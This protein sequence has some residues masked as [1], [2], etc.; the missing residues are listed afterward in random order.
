MSLFCFSQQITAWLLLGLYCASQ[1][2]VLLL[3]KFAAV[4]PAA[5]WP[6]FIGANVLTATGLWL[7]AIVLRQLNP[8]IATAM[9]LGGTFVAGQ[10]LLIWL[11][12]SRL[13]LAQTGGIALI[14][15]GLMLL[16][17]APG[18]KADDISKP[19]SSIIEEK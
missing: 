2:A 1:T 4:K 8:N 18:A 15:A 7:F 3:L 14:F 16:A 17:L 6:C 19:P 10:L 12:G 9:G 11:F 5:Y 13:S